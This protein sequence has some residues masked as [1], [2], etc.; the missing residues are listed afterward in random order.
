MQTQVTWPSMYRDVVYWCRSCH[1]CKLY[2]LRRLML[3]P[4]GRI[5]SYKIFSKWCL[6]IIGPLR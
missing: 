2:Q 3:E 5:L 1:Q 6:D 4:P